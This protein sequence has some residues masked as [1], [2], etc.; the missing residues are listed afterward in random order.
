[1]GGYIL[2]DLWRLCPERVKGFIFFNTRAERDGDEARAN[3]FK[4]AERA[5]NEK[6]FI[7]NVFVDGMISK[8]FSKSA[9]EAKEGIQFE[10]VTLARSW[11]QANQTNPSA[12]AHASI[13][14]AN[15]EDSVDLLAQISVPSLV[16]TGTEDP[17][18]GVN[19]MKPMSDKLPN[20][21]TV[22]AKGGSHL[23]PL[24]S[25]DDS[26]NAIIEWIQSIS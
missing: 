15:R 9:L 26:N 14:M 24:D 19:I 3:R 10:S 6:D 25:P 23:T 2:F 7:M 13:A 1:M 17:I 8:V 12:V 16:I 5:L 4:T 18:T 11:M 22:V 20:V 21:K